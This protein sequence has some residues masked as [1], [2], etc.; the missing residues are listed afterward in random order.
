MV[1]CMGH[2][3]SRERIID[4]VS[5]ITAAREQLHRLEGELDQLLPRDGAGQRKLGKGK[6]A[7]RGSLALRVVQLMEAEPEQAFAVPEV[8]KRLAVSSLPSLRKTVL[9]LA[10]Q[11]KIQRRRRGMYGAAQRRPS[12]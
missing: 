11:R 8:A 1:L 4:I 5:Q 10:A 2:M 6:R 3:T 9:R 12:Q 7:P